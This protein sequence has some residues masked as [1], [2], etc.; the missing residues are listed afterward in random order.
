METN[1]F[2][3][4]PIIKTS[5]GLI[6]ISYYDNTYR[7]LTVKKKISYAYEYFIKSIHKKKTN[8]ELTNLFKKMTFEEKNTL[9]TFDINFILYRLFSDTDIIDKNKSFIISNFTKYYNSYYNHT[10]IFNLLN[11][12]SSS[13]LEYDL[14]RGRVNKNE[15][16]L[17]TAI[18]EFREETTL[19][20][21]NYRLFPQFR[22]N[23]NISDNNINYNYYYFLAYL[24]NNILNKI[25]KNNTNYINFYNKKQ[26]EE[27][28]ELRW[29]TLEEF[30]FYNPDVYKIVHKA[31]KYLKKQI[32]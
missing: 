2:K 27:L 25:N 15:K 23:I 29:L 7:V 9:A 28:S 30:K 11:T 22:A 13:L 31:T 20:K 21:K 3:K 6:C 8:K 12:T 24:D 16:L 14:P 4:T 19:T 26:A 32:R 5:S 10:L 1:N 18:R 17:E